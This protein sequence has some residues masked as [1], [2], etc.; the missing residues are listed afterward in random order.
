M[1]VQNKKSKDTILIKNVRFLI[2]LQE[3]LQIHMIRALNIKII[4]IKHINVEKLYYLLVKLYMQEFLLNK[5]KSEVLFLFHFKSRKKISNNNMLIMTII[6]SLI[7]HTLQSCYM[8]NLLHFMIKL[9]NFL[10]KA[11]KSVMNPMKFL[12][13]FKRK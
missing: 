7:L 2:S 11:L 12:I 8:E 10:N 5:Q 13:K 6:I 3:Y 1:K 9:I 4:Q